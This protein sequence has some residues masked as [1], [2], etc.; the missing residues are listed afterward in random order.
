M[1]AVCLGEKNAT[2]HNAGTGCSC[3]A[4]VGATL[5]TVP[6]NFQRKL[7]PQGIKF[8]GYRIVYISCTQSF[9]N[10]WEVVVFQ[11]FMG[12]SCLFR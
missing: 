4:A 1:Y 6:S 3:C 9:Y 2:V 12:V 11:R 10:F 8:A 5:L 7:T